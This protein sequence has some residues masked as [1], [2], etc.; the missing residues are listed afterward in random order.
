MM[1]RFKKAGRFLRS[2]KC[3]VI[4][5][6]ILA[7]ACTLG[8]LVPQGQT[9]AYYTAN[10][11]ES[12][13]GAILLF[14]L[15][16]VFHC[17]WFVGLTLF[18]CLNLLLCSVLRFPVLMR[19][20]KEGFTAAGR[21]AGWDGVPAAVTAE[22]PEELFRQLGFHNVTRGVVSATQPPQETGA[23]VVVA[24]DPE[25]PLRQ[26]GLHSMTQGVVPAAQPPQETGAAVVV[27]EDPENTGAGGG[28]ASEASGQVPAPAPV[29]AQVPGPAPAG[30]ST[31]Y[32][33]RHR[34]GIWGSWLCH[35]GMLVVIAGFGLGQ[36]FQ[37]Q[38]SVYGVPGQVKPIGDTGYELRIDDFQVKLREDDTVEQYKSALTVS[39]AG[40]SGAAAE[41]GTGVVSVNH[42][43][44]LHGMKFYQNSTGWAANVQIYKDRELLQEGVICAGEYALVED[45]E[46]LAVVLNAFYP[47]YVRG[48]DGM[49]MT[50]SPE[51]NNPGYLYTLYYHD[52]ILG[53]NVLTEDEMI[54]VED[55]GIRFTDPQQYT[56]IQI[57][58]DPF[59]PVAAVGGLLVMISLVLAFYLPPEE[60]WAVQR[61]DG[62]WALAGRSRK[63]GAYFMEELAKYGENT[64]KSGGDGPGAQKAPVAGEAD[65]YSV[66]AVPA[67][68][69]ENT[70]GN[71]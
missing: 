48:A 16:D 33:V 40:A 20:M 51:L 61:A 57:K 36:M 47:D 31:R 21:I 34:F 23:A 53:M 15:D 26:L 70:D 11:P 41:E 62:T 24:E 8:S 46:G 29:S 52:Q 67:Q 9:A 5:L 66:K 12:L 69:N 39:R 35:L 63:A 58:R 38:Y 7:L 43:L 37:V 18:L 27:A 10:Y 28:K 50:A 2:M 59:T 25:E 30:C 65:P 32:A 1:E 13:A 4:L 6:V 68:K 19:R 14:R 55:Y 60:V 17:W 49:P 3:A 64:R 45:M 44:T 22:D 56:L 71:I 54:T 42:P